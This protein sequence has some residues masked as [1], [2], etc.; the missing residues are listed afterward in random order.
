MTLSRRE[1]KERQKRLNLGIAR[2]AKDR[3][4]PPDLIRYQIAFEGFL[5]RVFQDNSRLWGLKGGAAL[6]MRNGQGRTTTD[7]DLARARGLGSLAEV[8]AEMCEIA[9]RQGQGPLTYRVRSA[10]V[11]NIGR[12]D[13]NGPTYEIAVDAML[14]AIVF[15][16]FTLD[17][18]EQ[19]HTQQPHALVVVEP[20]LGELVEDRFERF[21]VSATAIESQLADKICAM[22]E[23]HRSGYSTRYHDLADIISI[24]Q[25]Q[26]V[27][28][29]GLFDACW[30]EAQRRG[31]KIPERIWVPPTWEAEFPR[32]AE[33]YYG[34]PEQY[35]EL[36]TAVAYV[37]SVLN[38][39]FSG[40]L[41]GKVWDPSVQL[42]KIA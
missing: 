11:K 37:S 42:W 9:S 18:T 8:E 35:R 33:T 17:L 7:I 6:L 15:Q 10:N 14:G 1:S 24:L 2:R 32:K 20:I 40:E 21:P 3:N 38:P 28:A 29:Q 27:V 19:R 22:R 5:E 39:V 34:L 41:S 12:D 36:P 4:Q 13:Y 23:M 25:T 31:L 16:A 30:H 26:K